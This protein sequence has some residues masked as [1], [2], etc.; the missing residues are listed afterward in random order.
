MNRGTPVAPRGQ[1]QLNVP[2]KTR[3]SHPPLWEAPVTVTVYQPEPEPEPFFFCFQVCISRL[4][5]Y[6]E[7]PEALSA[8]CSTVESGIIAEYSPAIPTLQAVQD[9]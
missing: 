5:E 2:E 8:R 1:P 6:P 4:T 9:S 7:S 3:K